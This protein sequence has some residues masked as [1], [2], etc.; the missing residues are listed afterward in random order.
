[1]VNTKQILNTDVY[2]KWAEGWGADHN[3]VNGSVLHI[4]FDKIIGAEH[5]VFFPP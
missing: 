2:S 1:M 5:I 3:T 4:C